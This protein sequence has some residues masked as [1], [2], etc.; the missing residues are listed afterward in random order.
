[1]IVFW[2]YMFNYYPD[3][4]CKYYEWKTKKL[5]KSGYG[6][7]YKEWLY[8]KTMVEIRPELFDDKTKEFIKEQGETP[9][10]FDI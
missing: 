7:S 3:F 8:G 5:M 1:M 10:E 6:L 4:I 2:F 9:M